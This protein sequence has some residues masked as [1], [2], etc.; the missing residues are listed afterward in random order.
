MNASRVAYIDVARGILMLLVILGHM[1][2]WGT[3]YIFWFHMPAFFMISGSV[4]SDKEW[5][6]KLTWQSVKKKSMR[7]FIPYVSYFFLLSIFSCFL[8]GKIDVVHLFL[9]FIYGGRLLVDIYSIFWFITCLFICYYLFILLISLK[10]SIYFQLVILIASYFFGIH[11]KEL[12]PK[13]Y[14]PWNFDVA[15]VAVIYFYIG[16]HFRRFAEISRI[17]YLF[18]IFITL[19]LASTA[20]IYLDLFIF[21]DFYRLN[22]KNDEFNN[23]LL[24]VLIPFIFYLTILIFSYYLSLSKYLS[25][26]LMIIGNN[27]LHIMYL[28]F[29]IIV[30]LRQYGIDNIAL[31]FFMACIV[32]VIFAFIIKRYRITDFLFNGKISVSHTSN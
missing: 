11:I 30:A 19:L 25:K 27:T 6:N 32:P 18:L 21:P 23:I 24:D 4:V 12:F 17:K 31:I 10:L 1:G 16:Y 7:Y 2:I 3:K 13:H 15:F 29:L 26:A 20:L 9:R 14:T 8:T 5:I 28:H 22:M